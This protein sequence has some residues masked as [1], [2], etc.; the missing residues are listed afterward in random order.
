[1]HSMLHETS[2]TLAL[3]CQK[4]VNA[5]WLSKPAQAICNE[6]QILTLWALHDD[7]APL[8]GLFGEALHG[9]GLCNTS[10]I[11]PKGSA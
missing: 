1:M 6:V 10:A 3:L 5:A 7:H 8:K 9:P 4:L 2:P 11:R